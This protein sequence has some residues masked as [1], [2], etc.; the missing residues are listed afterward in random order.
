MQRPTVRAGRDLVFR[1]L[2]LLTRQIERRRNIGMQLRIKGFRA[3][4]QCLDVF[5]R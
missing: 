5:D 3:L 4:D 1:V 2:C